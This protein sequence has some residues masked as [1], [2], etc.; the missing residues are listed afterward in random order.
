MHRTASLS[1]VIEYA[2]Y[3]SSAYSITPPLELDRLL[4]DAHRDVGRPL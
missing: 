2:K 1:P 4:A 3:G